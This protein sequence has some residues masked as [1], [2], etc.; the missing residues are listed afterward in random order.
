MIQ[1]GRMVESMQ[2]TNNSTIFNRLV[3]FGCSHTVGQFL[4][5]WEPEPG[6]QGILSNLAWSNHL[7]EY[8]NIPEIINKASGGNSNHEI[9]LNI[10]NFK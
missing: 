6:E 9:L 8:L 5:G 7:A 10:M 3:V 2:N 4:P 1:I